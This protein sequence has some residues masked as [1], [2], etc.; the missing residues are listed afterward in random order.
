VTGFYALL[1]AG[2]PR[3]EHDAS[4]HGHAG[5]GIFAVFHPENK[6]VDRDPDTGKVPGDLIEQVPLVLPAT[7]D[8]DEDIRVAP[9]DCPAFCQGTERMTLSAQ[10]DATSPCARS[11]KT[12]VTSSAS[13]QN[14]LT[15]S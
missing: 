3:G 11:F 15:E 9:W 4:L 14:T 10:P 6:E 7:R 13:S 12:L 1:P 5:E 8:E 2:L